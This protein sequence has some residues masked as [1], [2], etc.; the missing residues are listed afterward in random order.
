[1][2]DKLFP[3]TTP[4]PHFDPAKP[5][6]VNGYLYLPAGPGRSVTARVAAPRP[7]F[8]A[9]YVSPC[10]LTVEGDEH[11]CSACGLRWDLNE[12]RPQCLKERTKP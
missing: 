11:H 8:A 12:T 9:G 5:V 7:A 4:D 2:T 6:T 3:L 1:M 10:R